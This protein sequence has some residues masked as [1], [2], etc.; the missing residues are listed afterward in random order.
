MPDLLLPGIH[1]VWLALGWARQGEEAEEHGTASLL[2]PDAKP[3]ADAGAGNGPTR[4]QPELRS[5]SL[6]PGAQWAL[7]DRVLWGESPRG[8][9]H[10][11]HAQVE[12]ASPADAPPADGAPETP[13]DAA[14]SGPLPLQP[15]QRVDIP[16]LV[17][18]AMI[19]VR[20]CAMVDVKGCHSH[21][22]GCHDQGAGCQDKG[23]GCHGHL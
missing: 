1:R 20:K 12:L 2:L 5:P 22:E 7:G 8:I 19:K 9:V 14:A 6:C 17:A 3:A 11:R 18:E 4:Q 23:A 13:K 15:V 16:T 10:V 21:C